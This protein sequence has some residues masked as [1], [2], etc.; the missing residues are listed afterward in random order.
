MKYVWSQKSW[1]SK[2]NSKNGVKY[3]IK[4]KTQFNGTG[5][6]VETTS[7][8]LS[9][10]FID[11]EEGYMRWKDPNLVLFVKKKKTSRLIQ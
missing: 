3:V 9:I 5:E 6:A 4:K 8:H 10:K 1:I 7:W 11:I 2:Q